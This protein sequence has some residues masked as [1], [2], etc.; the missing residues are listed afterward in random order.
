M[1]E[2]GRDE[3]ELVLAL[4]SLSVDQTCP[5]L[6]GILALQLIKTVLQRDNSL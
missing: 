4:D 1:Q 3:G 5:P 6:G 2:V